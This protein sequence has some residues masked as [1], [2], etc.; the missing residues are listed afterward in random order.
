MEKLRLCYIYMYCIIFVYFWKIM[1]SH[2][3]GFQQNIIILG[4]TIF[5]MNHNIFR[6]SHSTNVEMLTITW[7][8]NT[9]STGS[10]VCKALCDICLSYK[11]GM[12]GS[13]CQ[14]CQEFKL[15]KWTPW[16]R[17]IKLIPRKNAFDY[18]GIWKV[19]KIMMKVVFFIS[20]HCP[21]FCYIHN[22]NIVSS[23]INHCLLQTLMFT[24]VYLVFQFLL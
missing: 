10:I 5:I 14:E 8:K 20:F 3:N 21:V 1:L 15:S 23:F 11:S 19:A 13:K 24:E 16:L 9:R 12:L 22:N 4:D 7:F 2:K 17:Q 6:C 18:L